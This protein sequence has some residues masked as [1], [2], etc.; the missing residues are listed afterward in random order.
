MLGVCNQRTMETK[1]R[2]VLEEYC[3]ECLRNIAAIPIEQLIEAMGLDIDYQYLTKNGDKV[4]GKLICSDGVTPY[5]DME[6]QKYMFL[7]VSAKTILVEVRLSEHDNK[8]R[9]RFTLAHELAHWILHKELILSDNT[10]AA[11]IDGVHNTR[12]EK[13]ADYFASALLMPMGAVKKYYYSLFG[14]GYSRSNLIT[15][16]AENF[17]VSKQA[18]QIRLESHNLI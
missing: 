16:M 17:Q 12:M 18:M 7:K 14:K 6:L 2:M 1:A 9:Y 11:F 10:E 3:P 8:G 5:Y 13:Q 15:A 4:L